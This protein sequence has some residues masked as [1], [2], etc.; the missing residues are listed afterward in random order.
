MEEPIE[1]IDIQQHLL[2]SSL[3]DLPEVITRSLMHT[4]LSSPLEEQTE[5]YDLRI[6]SLSNFYAR[7]EIT[8][9]HKPRGSKG[10]WV[11]INT[12]DTI[13]IT[14]GTNGDYVHISKI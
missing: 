4:D 13:R 14:K 2:S 6:D 5:Q 7:V 1:P 9:T 8:V 11:T 10:V 3:E 12:G